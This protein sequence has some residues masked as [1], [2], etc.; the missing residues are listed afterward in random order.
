MDHRTGFMPALYS[1]P[2][3]ELRL[4]HTVPVPWANFCIVAQP[5]STQDIVALHH[6]MAKCHGFTNV[7]EVASYIANLFEKCMSSFKSHR[8]EQPQLFL[9]VAA[10]VSEKEK[11]ELYAQE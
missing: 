8:P 9:T 5:S 3:N 4:A 6:L 7:S 11:N 2:L 10:T 1:V